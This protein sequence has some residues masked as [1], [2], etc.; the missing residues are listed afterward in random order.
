MLLKYFYD[1]ELAQA[2]YMVGC[3]ATGE[4]LIIDPFVKLVTCPLYRVIGYCYKISS[5][6]LLHG[7]HTLTV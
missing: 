2:S 7:L 6:D 5:Y 1:K 4:A 3:S